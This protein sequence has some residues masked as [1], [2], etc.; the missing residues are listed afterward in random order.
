MPRARESR[1]VTTAT[2][3]QRVDAPESAQSSLPIE[4]D[5]NRFM[6]WLEHAP[7]EQLRPHV[8]RLLELLRERSFGLERVDDVTLRELAVQA[9]LR[10]GY[11]W[12]LALDPEDLTFVREQQASGRRAR[13]RS[14][15]RRLMPLGL[16][17]VASGFAVNGFVRAVG[18]PQQN[19]VLVEP[20]SVTLRAPVSQRVD[21]VE[22]ALS[23]DL[24]VLPVDELV[25]VA[26]RARLLEASVDQL[27]ARGREVE[28]CS[29]ALDCLAL[30]GADDA[31]C[32]MALHRSV[33][34]LARRD[35]REGLT[36]RERA[37][38]A[39]HDE[40]LVVLASS[41]TQASIEQALRRLEEHALDGETLQPSR[42][43]L[44]VEI[45]TRGLADQLFL[46]S[47]APRAAAVRRETRKALGVLREVSQGAV[48]SSGTSEA[49]AHDATSRFAR[50]EF[51][52]ALSVAERCVASFPADL[53]CLAVAATALPLV[54]A[55]SSP[56]DRTAR[57]ATMKERFEDYR[58]Q[59]ARVLAH[60]A[61]ER[62][63]AQPAGADES[64]PVACP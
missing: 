22:R 37:E 8:P 38:Q 3:A 15:L 40:K 33:S 11:P 26:D 55:A 36:D 32:A 34:A 20:R 24:A 17:L 35:T 48:V 64:R 63:E 47:E 21:A 29:V 59:M 23:P 4:D 58:R 41:G 31:R 2:R 42:R 25:P 43:R 1:R 50:G 5:P 51:S 16:V 6:A 57:E 44:A 53:G 60:A 62:C 9:V 7:V 30:S 54:H 28:A 18:S 46:F 52:A 19:V 13:R 10:A 45:A 61:R 49:M 14:L 12:A 27:V 56:A 39:A